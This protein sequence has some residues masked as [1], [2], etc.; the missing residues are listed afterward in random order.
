M[1][2]FYKEFI[3]ATIEGRAVKYKFTEV[4]RVERT[5]FMSGRCIDRNHS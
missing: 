3:K 5:L 1:L 4:L 2:D